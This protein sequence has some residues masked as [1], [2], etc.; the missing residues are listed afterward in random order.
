[1][2]WNFVNNFCLTESDYL[3]SPSHGRYNLRVLSYRLLD[4]LFFFQPGERSPSTCTF[5]Q[6]WWR[7]TDSV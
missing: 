5:H 1:V 6:N 7:D 3:R 4:T 2:Q